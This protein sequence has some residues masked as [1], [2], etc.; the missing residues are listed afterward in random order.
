MNMSS[1]SKIKAAAICIAETLATSI[2]AVSVFR[3]WHP[4]AQAEP[5][6]CIFRD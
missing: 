1:E 4:Q 5:I 2:K 6:A 3:L